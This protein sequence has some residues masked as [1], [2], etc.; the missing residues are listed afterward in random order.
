MKTYR[1]NAN[2]CKA[3][4]ERLGEGQW[5]LLVPDGSRIRTLHKSEK[6]A[7]KKMLA[8]RPSWRECDADDMGCDRLT[9]ARADEAAC[10]FLTC[11]GFEVM[12]RGW[13]CPYGTIDIVGWDGDTLVFANVTAEMKAPRHRKLTE[14]DRERL[15]AIALEYI[16]SHD[17]PECTVRFDGV[18]VLV[19]VR[20]AGQCLIRHHVGIT[21]GM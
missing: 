8:H 17:L 10:K 11:H 14:A 4:I 18:S 6:G 21:N 20:E 3:E 5:R 2:G 12:E 19:P 1:N 16:G 9:L 7:Y 13:G 15:E